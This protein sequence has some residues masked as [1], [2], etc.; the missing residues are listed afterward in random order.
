MLVKSFPDTSF[1]LTYID[2]RV[3]ITQVTDNFVHHIFC[4]TASGQSR[5]TGVTPSGSGRAGW[6]FEGRPGDMFGQ[7]FA[8]WPSHACFQTR[9]SDRTIYS[10][11]QCVVYVWERYVCCVL[12]VTLLWT[13]C[14]LPRCSRL[15]CS[16]WRRFIPKYI[17]ATFF[18]IFQLNSS[19]YHE[20]KVTDSFIS[21]FHHA[22][23]RHCPSST[24]YMNVSLLLGIG[25]DQKARVTF[26]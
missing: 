2:G 6:S 18:D 4:V 13:F 9:R 11:C 22:Q 12:G 26:D 10:P 3:L 1:G 16:F 24:W 5:F 7:C 25:L 21:Y 14:V 20:H 15:K 19:T 23:I 17:N 8:A